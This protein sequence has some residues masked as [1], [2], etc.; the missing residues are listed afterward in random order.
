M[1]NF[2][3]K[4]IFG[5][6]VISVLIVSSQDTYAMGR[7]PKTFNIQLKVDFGPAGKPAYDQPLEVERGSTAKDA[8][9]QVFPI[10]SGKFCCSLREVGAIDGIKTEPANSNWWICLLNGS[11]NFNPRTKELKPGDVV[12][13]KYIHE[14]RGPSGEKQQ[15]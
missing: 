1:K 6:A 5:L 11:K 7:K 9:A 15:S 12:E 13:W 14:V 8:V 4:S 3:H 10:Q 2:L